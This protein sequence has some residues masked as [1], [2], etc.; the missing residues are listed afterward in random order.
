MLC[1]KLRNLL[2][3]S[4][5]VLFALSGCQNQ[6]EPSPQEVSQEAEANPK[7]DPATAKIIR[8]LA[9]KA[10]GISDANFTKLVNGGSTPSPLCV[11]NQPLSLI[12]LCHKVM[13]LPEEIVKQRSAEFQ[14]SSSTPNATKLVKLLQPTSTIDCWTALH[15]EYIQNVTCNVED[16]TATGEISFDAELYAGKVQYVASKDKETWQI[17]EFSFP[18]RNWR[19]VRGEDG[20]WQ[21]HDRFGHITKERELPKQLVVGEVLIDDKQ[22]QRGRLVFTMRDYPEFYFLTKAGPNGE[23][24]VS[25]PAGKYIVTCSSRELSDRF[26]DGAKSGLIVDIEEGQSKLVLKIETTPSDLSEVDL[27]PVGSELR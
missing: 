22:M 18:V 19:F 6:I 24:G 5:L 12:I 26:S 13:S 1:S 25:L 23:F 27:S 17:N 8:S 16:D 2:V 14:F 15:P 21:W 11:Q 10:A 3:L 4:S 9:A 20:Y 7:S